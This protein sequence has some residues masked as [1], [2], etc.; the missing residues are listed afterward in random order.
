MLSTRWRV[1]H[2]G[3]SRPG[4]SCKRARSDL[5]HAMHIRWR[6]GSMT[7]VEGCMG[8]KHTGQS[9]ASTAAITFCSAS[10]PGATAV[11]GPAAVIDSS[12]RVRGER[13]GEVSKNPGRM[14]NL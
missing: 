4:V 8:S 10:F 9:S 13:R 7:E 11:A 3:Q 12:G 14:L 6:H 1:R 5:Q 2:N